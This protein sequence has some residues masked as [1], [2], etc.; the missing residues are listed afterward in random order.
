MPTLAFLHGF[1]GSPQDWEGVIAHLPQ[2]RCQ[3]LTYP[4]NPPPDSLLIGYSMGGRIALQSNQD[5]IA[6]SAHPGLSSNEKP[7]DRSLWIER[8]QSL[9]FETFL[10]LWYAQPLF[11]AFRSHPIFPQV[12]ARRL[13]VDP[14]TALKQLTSHPLQQRRAHAFFIYGAYDIKYQ[15]LYNGL[16][17]ICIER[18]GHV[19]HLE[20]PKGCANAIRN[21]LEQEPRFLRYRIS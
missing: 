16:S 11:D 9:P 17:A 15:N 19:C 7:P 6:I 3:P 2:Y 5:V 13:Q 10:D 20:N 21:I 18:S 8:L 14:L 4:F 12:W 1:L